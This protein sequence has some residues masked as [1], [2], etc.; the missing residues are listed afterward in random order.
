MGH[1]DRSTSPPALDLH[2]LNRL[3]PVAAQLD[4]PRPVW[5]SAPVRGERDG[6]IESRAQ[7]RPLRVI[8]KV[9]PDSG[10][11]TGKIGY[12]ERN[13]VDRVINVVIAMHEGQYFG[14]LNQAILLLNAAAL[15]VLLASATVM[16]WRRRPGDAL[17]APAPMARPRFSALL[18]VVVLAL[19]ALLPL[20]ALTLLLVLAT[21]RT[22]LRRL[23]SARRWLGLDDPRSGHIAAARTN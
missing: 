19:S 10:L 21:E 14:R 9:A 13:V 16:W 15:L 5:I 17:G 20:F 7:N 6:Q 8:Y 1:G 18:V 2:A 23:P 12:A 22:L 3:V 11:V 4:L